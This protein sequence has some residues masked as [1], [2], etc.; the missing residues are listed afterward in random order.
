MTGEIVRRVPPLSVPA[1][2]IAP[3]AESVAPFEAVQLFV[4]RAVAAESRF[5]LTDA[6]AAAVAAICQRLDVAA[7]KH[8]HADAKTSPFST[9]TKCE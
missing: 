2:A 8:N 5:A 7:Q 9:H 3:S 1:A 4:D 6:N